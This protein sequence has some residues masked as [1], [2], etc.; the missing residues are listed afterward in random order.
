MEKKF[1]KPHDI[2]RL[3]MKLSGSPMFWEIVGVHLAGEHNAQESIV[4]I[5]PLMNFRTKGLQHQSIPA[6]ILD[7]AIATGAIRLYIV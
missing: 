6:H 2:L 4:M 5:E 1:P 7:A 3:D